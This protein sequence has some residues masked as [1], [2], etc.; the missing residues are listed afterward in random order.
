MNYRPFIFSLF[1]GLLSYCVLIVGW[2][3]IGAAIVI[4]GHALNSYVE[5]DTFFNSIMDVVTI[6]IP[7]YVFL[8]TY[9]R[10][11]RKKKNRK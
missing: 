4:S 5:K 6:L 3:A 10:V 11:D 9:Q 8:Y 2:G 1:F 7:L